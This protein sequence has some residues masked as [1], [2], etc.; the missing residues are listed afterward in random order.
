MNVHVRPEG[1]KPAFVPNDS[2]DEINIEGVD[3]LDSDI[4]IDIDVDVDFHSVDADSDF[5]PNYGKWSSP[6][7]PHR[8]WSCVDKSA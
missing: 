7:V 4:D 3:R 2:G 6:G 5:H 1:R 8:G